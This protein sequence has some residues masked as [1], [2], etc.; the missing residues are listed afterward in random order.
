MFKFC[1]SCIIYLLFCSSWP[2][3]VVV[4]VASLSSL[5]GKSQTVSMSLELSLFPYPRAPLRI[6]TSKSYGKRELGTIQG[7]PVLTAMGHPNF[8]FAF[9]LREKSFVVNVLSLKFPSCVSG[10]PP[11]PPPPKRDAVLLLFF[12]EGKIGCDNFG[13]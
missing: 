3:R 7:E 6:V 12:V 9:V 8:V 1:S 13:G 2:S 5:G 11:S 4:P 10:A